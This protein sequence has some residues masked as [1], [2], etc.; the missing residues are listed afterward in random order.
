MLL[1][2]PRIATLSQNEVE[3]IKFK[4]DKFSLINQ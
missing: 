3:Q 1:G 4:S 2:F